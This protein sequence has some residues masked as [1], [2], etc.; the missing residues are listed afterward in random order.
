MEAVAHGELADRPPIS[1]WRHFPGR[2]SNARDLAKAMIEFQTTYDWDYLKVNPRAV[3][4]HEAWGNEYDYSK[5]NDIMPTRVKTLVNGKEDLKL[6]RELSG[7]EGS[8]ADQLEALRLIKAELGEEVPM[9]QTIF[10]PI[11]I[12]AN[13]CGLRSLGRYREAPREQSALIAMIQEDPKSVHAALSAIA[14][15]LAKYAAAVLKTGV[16]GVFYA[17]LG[18]ARTGYFPA[19]N[20]M[21]S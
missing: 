16:D 5:Y 20:G 19:G 8:F 6:I 17:A 21:S 12:L 18:M 14:K 3:Y 11:G 15:T 4:Y 13:L 10:T 7:V 1:A 9:F 2:E